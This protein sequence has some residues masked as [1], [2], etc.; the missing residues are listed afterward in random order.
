[1]KAYNRAMKEY[2]EGRGWDV[3]DELMNVVGFI[4]GHTEFTAKPTDP[5]QADGVY[6]GACN[7]LP[8]HPPTH[9]SMRSPI[10]PSI[11]PYVERTRQN[12]SIN[13]APPH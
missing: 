3:P 6:C 7:H 11:L 8:I 12:S 4:D 10:Y 13:S 9:P 2:I 1:M 5:H